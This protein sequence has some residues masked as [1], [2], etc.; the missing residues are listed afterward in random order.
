M[1]FTRK[2]QKQRV[3]C[4]ND[5]TENM[6][7]PLLCDNN[8][9]LIKHV[10]ELVWLKLGQI[11]FLRQTCPGFAV[12][13]WIIPAHTIY[14]SFENRPGV[15][16]LDNFLSNGTRARLQRKTTSVE[17]VWVFLFLRLWLNRSAAVRTI[18]INPN[19]NN[20]LRDSD[21]TGSHQASIPPT[22]QNQ[23][24]SE[25]FWKKNKNKAVSR[26]RFTQKCR[27]TLKTM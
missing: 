22:P 7:L 4:W 23:L 9:T 25:K 5:F 27:K 17:N 1:S 11:Q 14:L 3:L 2:P 10:N 15:R 19:L 26:K 12:S 24:L 8:W 6:Q 21:A 13:Y 16:L 18:K 20:K